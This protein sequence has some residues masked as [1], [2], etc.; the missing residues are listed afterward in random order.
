TMPAWGGLQIWDRVTGARLR[1]LPNSTA[2]GCAF[3]T[4]GS[5]LVL[6]ESESAVVWDIDAGRE[7]WRPRLPPGEG[8]AAWSPDG[9]LVAVQRVSVVCVLL[10]AAT[11]VV[12]ARLQHPDL[13]PYTALAFSPDSGQ[14]ACTSTSH[15]VHLWNFRALRR[16]L[17]A[18]RLDWQQPPLSEVSA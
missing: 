12:V 2:G 7:V 14:L 8:P 11:G 15:F 10:D 17:A 5:R 18:L 16:E 9:R 3:N 13:Y 6:N 1:Q 4:D